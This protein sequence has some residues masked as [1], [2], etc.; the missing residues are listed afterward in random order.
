MNG[1]LCSI[2]WVGLLLALVR[3]VPIAGADP[4]RIYIVTDLEG[5]SGVYQFAQTREPGHPL[6]EKAKEYLMATSPRSSAGCVPAARPTSSCSTATGRRPS[7]R[8]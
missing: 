7:C 5:A 2:R 4:I 3:F 8:I 6:G 1:R